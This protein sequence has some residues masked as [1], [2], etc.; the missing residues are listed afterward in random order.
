MEQ[1]NI[2]HL[3]VTAVTLTIRELPQDLSRR[4]D[5]RAMQNGRSPEDEARVLLVASL[6]ADARREDALVAIEETRAALRAANGGELPK[7]VVEEFLADKR[8]H[9]AEELA[10][11]EGY[12]EG[13]SSA[14]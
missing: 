14:V 8:R 7:G 11:I 1:L 4:L 9:G 3:G 6:T 2:W 13:K 12:L 10:R 5:A